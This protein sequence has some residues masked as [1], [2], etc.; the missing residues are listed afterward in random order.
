VS[1]EFDVSKLKDAVKEFRGYVAKAEYSEAPFGIHGNPA[2]EEAQ[3][4]RGLTKKLGVMILTEEYDKPQY[5]WMYPSDKKGTKWSYFISALSE[6]GAMAKILPK[7]AG[8]TVEE[9]MTSFANAMVNKE[10]LWCDEQIETVGERKT[11]I[12]LPKVFYGEVSAEKLV[13]AVKEVKVE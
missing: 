9:K 8:A 7:V 4:K 1:V 2:I 3:K 12:L 11:R 5:E 10:F 6:C 13:E